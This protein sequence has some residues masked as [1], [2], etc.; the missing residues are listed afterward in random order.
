MFYVKYVFLLAMSCRQAL[1]AI[2]IA[3]CIRMF[4]TINKWLTYLLTQ[5]SRQN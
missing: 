1:A 5:Y 4:L 2:S 3:Y